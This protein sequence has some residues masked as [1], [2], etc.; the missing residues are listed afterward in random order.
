M[1]LSQAGIELTTRCSRRCEHCLRR[2][3]PREAVDLDAAL[4][5]RLVPEL[6]ARGA[7]HLGLTGGEP[8][9]HPRIASVG[10]LL[11][12]RGATFHLVT[13]GGHTRA[14]RALIEASGPALTRVAVSLDGATAA[15]HD[16]CRGEGAFT[17]ALQTFSLCARRQVPVVAQ[18]TL[19]RRNVDRIEDLASLA[20]DL[21]A[22]GVRYAFC[23]PYGPAAGLALDAETRRV[24]A[25]RIAQIRS[26]GPAVELAATDMA[27]GPRCRFL[28]L[29]A[30]F[31]DARGRL[32]YCCL[33]AGL[34]PDGADVAADLTRTSLS[35]GIAALERSYAR[36]RDAVAAGEITLGQLDPREVPPC[37]LCARWMGV[38]GHWR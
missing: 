13:G 35:E 30:V 7:T 23:Q 16:A 5:E 29:D 17:E 3:A 8:L 21:G 36:F 24:A 22:S 15:D 14:L 25:D 37:G 12:R 27:S 26:A 33:L 10:G 4:L 18:V 2:A 31:I 32:L 9:L 1:S 28:D 19:T 34:C 6:A 11:A 38:G 20:R